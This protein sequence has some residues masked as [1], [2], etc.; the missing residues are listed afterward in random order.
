MKLRNIDIIGILTS[1]NG[2]SD[3][4]LPQ[5]IS[6]AITKN[7][8]ILMKENECYQKE[9]EKIISE[10]DE[11][12]VKNDNR[13]DFHPN[14]VPKFKEDTDEKFVKE[15]HD[16]LDEL[17]SIESD[18]NIYTIDDELLN[19]DDNGNYDVLTPN[20]ISY[21]QRVLCKK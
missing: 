20:E 15:F 7:Q 11:Y 14:G 3:K 21:I 6:Y 12:F 16:K 5:K 8:M 19:Y 13:I 17:L 10:Y 9:F 4:K 18:V 2:F 1:L